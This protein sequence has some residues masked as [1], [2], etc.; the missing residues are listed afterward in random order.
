MKNGFLKPR[1][2]TGASVTYEYYKY[3][4]RTPSYEVTAPDPT[5]AVWYIRDIVPE[6]AY[7]F[8]DY[9]TIAQKRVKRLK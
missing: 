8:E 6:E 7:N 1:A 4:D 2:G 3:N 9:E 5:T